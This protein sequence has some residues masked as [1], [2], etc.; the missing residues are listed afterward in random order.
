MVCAVHRACRSLRLNH[1]HT[2]LLSALFNIFV[3]YFQQTGSLCERFGIDIPP[4]LSFTLS[5]NKKTRF[6]IE[7]QQF[8]LFLS[9]YRP[10][11][12]NKKNDSNKIWYECQLI[13]LQLVI[14]HTLWFCELSWIVML[15]PY[16][17][18]EY[19]GN[20]QCLLSHSS[21]ENSLKLFAYVYDIYDDN[22]V[23]DGH[24]NTIMRFLSCFE[25]C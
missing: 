6:Q 14:A 11:Y 17:H 18:M 21:L 12:E 20:G 4:Q 25:F 9:V 13:W 23:G 22:D 2:L 3:I 19:S 15:Y 24:T 10:N 5:T 16:S 7:K 1:R 8:F